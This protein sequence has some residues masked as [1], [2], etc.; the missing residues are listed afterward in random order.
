[1]SSSLAP[2]NSSSSLRRT[3]PIEATRSDPNIA[4]TRRRA[5][6]PRRHPAAT[7]A[8]GGCRA[9][10][11]SPRRGRPGRRRPGRAARRL[12]ASPAFPAASSAGEHQVRVRVQIEAL[13]LHVR[14]PGAAAGRPGHHPQRG[15]PVLQAPAG[16]VAGPVRRG[17]G[18]GSDHARRAD[19]QQRRQL[20]R[21]PAQNDVTLVGEPECGPSPPAIRLSSPR[22]R[23]RWTW[24]PLPTPG[25]ATFGENDVRRPYVSPTARMVERTSTEVSAAPPGPRRRPRARTGPVRTRDGTVRSRR[26]GRPAPRVRRPNSPRGRPVGSSRTPGRTRA[27][28]KSSSSPLETTHSISTAALTAKPCSASARSRDAAAAGCHCGCGS[29]SWSYRSP[30]AHAHPG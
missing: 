12:S 4:S 29:P 11:G 9:S 23:L 16:V 26:P 30:G 22:H 20:P 28:V 3:A 7:S 19:G 6:T 10:R 24:P 15:L 17:R 8:A 21:M 14:G 18:A 13:H 5:R 27:G 2:S 1:M 25:T